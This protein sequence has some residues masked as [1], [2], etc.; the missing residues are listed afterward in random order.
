M[1]KLPSLIAVSLVAGLL[2]LPL[3]AVKWLVAVVV[4]YTAIMMLRASRS[5]APAVSPDGIR[6]VATD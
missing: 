2:S 4:I 1:T 6:P 3:Q 5:A